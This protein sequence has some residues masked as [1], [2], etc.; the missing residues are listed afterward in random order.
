MNKYMNKIYGLLSLLAVLI[1]S[2]SCND[3]WKD[4][5]YEQYVSFK[6]PIG[7]EGVTPIYVRYK[8]D[9][10]TPY[11][12][13]LIVSGSVNNSADRTVHIAVD[14]DTLKQLNFERFQSRSDHYYKELD[15]EH[16]S[17]PETVEIKKGENT[18]LLEIN[19]SM[20]DVDLVDKWVLP[21][22]ILDDPSYNYVSHPRKHYKKALLRV[23]PFNDYSGRYS[24]TGL[25]VHLDGSEN[26]T[27]IVKET[28]PSYVVNENT[29]FFYAGNIDE[30]RIDRGKY[31]IYAEFNNQGGVK[32]F[33]ENSDIDFIVNKDPSYVIM[34]EMDKV[35]P[36]LKHRYLTIHN[37]DYEYTDYTMIPNVKIRYKVQGSLIIERK[38]NTQIP[39]ED[40][41]IEWD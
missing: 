36:Y 15:S 17:F 19:F 23:I 6:A 40:Q 34:E 32:F 33:S 21:L 41:A 37:I 2:S 24:G 26:E 8:S 31:K 1:F 10:S 16:F 20:K 7:S 27:P 12:L 11:Q 3:E 9:V 25:K 28:I 14:S 38:L 13:P 18:S 35:R 4:E 5:Q 29:I 30:E 22:T 39:D